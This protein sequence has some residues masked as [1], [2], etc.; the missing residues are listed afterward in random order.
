MMEKVEIVF[1]PLLG[2]GTVSV[3]FKHAKLDMDAKES[4]EESGVYWLGASNELLAIEFDEVNTKADTQVLSIP[5]IGATFK[6]TVKDGNV[7][8]E[9][10]LLNLKSPV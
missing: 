3:Y 6:L 2:S 5:E 10:P 7:S 9:S 4:P 8:L 1:R